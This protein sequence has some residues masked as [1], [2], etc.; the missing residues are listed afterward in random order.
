MAEAFG[1][2]IIYLG[3]IFLGYFLKQREILKKEDKKVLSRIIVNVTLPAMVAGS[4][5]EIGLDLWFVVALA[6]G[7]LANI[8]MIVIA[9]LLSRKKE[10][11]LQAMYIMNLPGYSFANITIPF[12][13]NIIPA[14]IPYLCMMDTGDSLF[15]LGT[16]YSIARAKL[17]NSNSISVPGMIKTVLKELFR[18]VPFITYMIMIVITLI[19][20]RLPKGIVSALMFAGKA[21]GFLA[22]IMIGLS[23]EF[24][25][26]V[27]QIKD[28]LQIIVARLLISLLIASIVLYLL[29]GPEAF[30][31]T[32]AVSVF[33][34]IP[35]IAVV[36]SE[37]AGIDTKIPGVLNSIS[38]ILA[39]PMMALVY[40]LLVL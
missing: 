32:M 4:F 23:L 17:S 24:S 35:N 30:R 9:L 40:T 3:T 16:T 7:I 36:Y 39:L 18:S 1:W 37:Y 25:M 34:G 13:S 21:N 14:G 19:G 38:T 5:A 26:E 8:I 20:L 2:T 6:L 28:I 10:A 15:T 27:N 33:S 29:P 11:S 12:L 31:I 22:M